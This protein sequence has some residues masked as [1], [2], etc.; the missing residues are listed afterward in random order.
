MEQIKIVPA[1]IQPWNRHVLAAAE[2][3]RRFA[4]C[5]TLAI[6]IY[7]QNQYGVFTLEKIIAH[8]QDTIS[9]ITW[10]PHNPE[11]LASCSVEKVVLIWDVHT[12]KIV[13]SRQMK[14]VPVAM[15]WSPFL[16]TSIAIADESTHLQAWD[17]TGPPKTRLLNTDA[18]AKVLRWST[19]VV[20]RLAQ[21][22][23][24]S[25]VHVVDMSR[26][27]LRRIRPESDTPLGYVVDVQWDPLSDNY[28]LI[29]F[30]VGSIRMFDVDTMQPM[31]LFEQP[32]GC[33][34]LRWIATVPG[35]FLSTDTK[36]GVIRIWNVS[37]SSPLELVKVRKVG[38]YNLIYVDRAERV[39]CTFRDGSFGVYHMVKRRWEFLSEPGHAETIFDCQFKTSNPNILATAS[40]DTTVKIWDVS[41]MKCI[42][43]LPGHEGVVYSIAWSPLDDDRLLA[44]SAKA[45][46][47]LWDTRKHQVLNRYAHHQDAIY[48]VA[49]NKLD[50][51]LF[52]S[53]SK[54]Q[55]CFVVKIDGQIVQRYKHPRAAYGCDWNPHNK[56]QLV[57]GCQDGNVRVFD[58]SLPAT[59]AA[60]V[61]SGHTARVFNTVWSPLLPNVLVSGS[62]D[63]TLRVWDAR[64]GESKVLRGHTNNV[65]AILWNPEIPWL[66]LSGSWDGTVRIW[67]TR[68]ATQV[69]VVHDHH[70]DVYGLASH[71]A[72]PFIVASCARDTTL[73]LWNL[74]NLAFVARPRLTLVC[75]SAPWRAVGVSAEQLMQTDVPWGFAGKLPVLIA[76][77]VE[78]PSELERMKTMFEVFSEPEGV[79]Q[80]CG[81]LHEVHTGKPA[82]EAPPG[83]HTIVHAS[84]LVKTTEGRLASDLERLRAGK[85]VAGIGLDSREKHTRDLASTCLRLGRIKDYCELLVD[86]NEWQLAISVAP[87]VSV[88]YWK[89]L[90]SRYA[91]KLAAED[92][93]LAEPLLIAT[94]NT[95]KLLDFYVS[96]NEMDEAFL[97]A[98]VES[99]GGYQA[100]SKALYI[101]VGGD[102]ASGPE[103][104][105]NQKYIQQV[106]HAK[107][108]RFLGEGQPLLA[109]CC[110]LAVSDV[111]GAIQKLLRGNRIEMAAT[112]ARVM[113]VEP[114]DHIYE[115]LSR[116]CERFGLWDLALAMLKLTRNSLPKVSMLCLR[117][118]ALNAADSANFFHKAG[119]R[120]PTAYADE[121]GLHERKGAAGILDAV[122]C[123][124]LS[125][126][127]AA[128]IRLG[129]DHIKSVLSHADWELT[130][131]EKI[132]N[133]LANSRL[134]TFPDKT[135]FEV[136][137]YAAFVGTQLAIWK[138]YT[139]VLRCM[140]DTAQRLISQHVPDFPV[141]LAHLQL[142]IGY[143]LAPHDAQAAL[144]L[145]SELA[146]D[147]SIAAHFSAA[148]KFQWQQLKTQLQAERPAE[149]LLMDNIISLSHL[150]AKREIRVESL[151]SR[152]P[153]QGAE[154]VL[155]DGRAVITLSEALMWANVNRFSPLCS[156]ACINPY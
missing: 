153:L 63:K 107:S 30:R 64:T 75:G 109:A 9:S 47:F 112:I 23:E 65:R 97:V 138:G 144:K 22:N 16:E 103:T 85:Y 145:F 130:T 101:N 20:G 124:L 128:A 10:S 90:G 45:K 132:L 126:N 17:Y 117:H 116:R 26:G 88:D 7:Q 133:L 125:G 51:N 102:D 127:A 50:A 15:D 57:T 99:A 142:Q 95:D 86:L 83:S 141:P 73:R 55:F 4:Y 115:A 143:Y 155:E 6:Y 135:R 82:A 59:T 137:A 149:P 18:K 24:D 113:K 76:R 28:L 154:F 38:F 62:D 33:S 27:I 72:R 32:G 53:C 81:L 36:T 12:E 152:L 105:K 37:Q 52:A 98:N 108:E 100:I 21:G 34:S 67:D 131:C 8:H 2:K 44:C 111:Q 1:G 148:A 123:H 54:D 140:F 56:H 3:G 5:S 19:R 139:P 60:R 89:A 92:K 122:R 40:F 104:A 69:D 29:G 119:L 78:A 94:N 150:P 61:L 136:L 49:W 35:G 114:A 134:E 43:S 118:Q 70:A 39:L 25:T 146:S 14:D 46:L 42:D 156:G 58:V 110:Y 48:T 13:A 31:R 106:T 96:R 120:L 80:L 66:L 77:M 129:I 79:E 87:A 11:L 91:Q 121:A 71:P 41:T 68:T 74:E 147:T 84:S 93:A 151:I